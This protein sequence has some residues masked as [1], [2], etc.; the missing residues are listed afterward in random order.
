[1]ETVF[2]F[3]FLMGHRQGESRCK[4]REFVHEKERKKGSTWE[5]KEG[6]PP[7]I[8]VLSNPAAAQLANPYWY[9]AG[10]KA[11]GT[12]LYQSVN[13]QTLFRSPN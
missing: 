12:P 10:D 9:L 7:L 6:Q 8:G 13:F 11:N 2:G 1:M 3:P 5:L 4:I